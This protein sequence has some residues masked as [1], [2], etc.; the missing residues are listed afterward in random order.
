MFSALI[1]TTFLPAAFL[2]AVVFFAA[3]SL[4][5]VAAFFDEAFFSAIMTINVNTYIEDIVPMWAQK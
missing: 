2:V 5:S 1:A 4:F 3:V